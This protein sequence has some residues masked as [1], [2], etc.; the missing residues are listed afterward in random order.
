M[1]PATR[2]TGSTIIVQ[3]LEDVEEYQCLPH[4]TFFRQWRV[5][6]RVFWTFKGISKL[7]TVYQSSNYPVEQHMSVCKV[8]CNVILCACSGVA[9]LLKMPGI[10]WRIK[11]HQQ[12][13]PYNN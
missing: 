11:H 12:L 2:Y 4:E 8:R 10:F 1:V 7:L 6:G 3:M 13:T 9:R 5:H